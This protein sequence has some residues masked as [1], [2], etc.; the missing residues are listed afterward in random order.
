M[1]RRVDCD[2]PLA[3][4]QNNPL[5]QQATALYV[6]SPVFAFQRSLTQFT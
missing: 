5:Y 4:Y 2:V 3:A 6:H 1:F